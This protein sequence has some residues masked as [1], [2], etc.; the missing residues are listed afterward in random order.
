MAPARQ[1]DDGI[2][3]NAA[4]FGGGASLFD[5]IGIG[6]EARNL[7]HVAQRF[8]AP[9]TAALRSGKGGAPACR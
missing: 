3:T 6:A 2:G 1:A 4:G 8:L 5:K 7:E 9:A